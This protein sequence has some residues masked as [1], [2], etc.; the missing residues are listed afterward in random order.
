MSDVFDDSD[1]LKNVRSFVAFMRSEYQRQ[2]HDGVKDEDP[3]T[4]RIRNQLA[5]NWPGDDVMQQIIK[6]AAT[7][8]NSNHIKPSD[9]K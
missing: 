4:I 1:D 7:I 2:L 9:I 5:T 6:D 8:M 3:L